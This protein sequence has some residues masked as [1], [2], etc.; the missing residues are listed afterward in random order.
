[1]KN[2]LNFALGL[3]AAYFAYIYFRKARAAKTL[4]I[5][6]RTIKL[7]PISQAAISLEI[8]NP[9]NSNVNFT[10]IV[11][12][13]I[14]NNFALGTLNYQ[15][16]T[17]IPANS[18]INVDLRIK[19][20]PLESLSFIAN[21]LQKQSENNVIKISGNVSGEGIVVPINIEQNLKF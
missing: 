4:N 10:S 3:G 2:Y 6:L 5:K 17:I 16:P 13:L 8:I 20:N 15:A 19:I 12:D 21:L 11:A 9:T 18:S 7:Q 14:I 1:M